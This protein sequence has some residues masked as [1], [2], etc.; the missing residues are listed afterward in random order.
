VHLP[1]EIPT[2]YK[3][4]N[5]MLQVVAYGSQHWPVQE[6]CNT[7]SLLIEEQKG[8]KLMKS[9]EVL[10]LPHRIQFFLSQEGIK[11][12]YTSNDNKNNKNTH[13]FQD[14]CASHASDRLM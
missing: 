9:M 11:L 2:L 10:K 14:S 13:T 7:G 1:E 12:A 5:I 4:R 8:R 6:N 3:A